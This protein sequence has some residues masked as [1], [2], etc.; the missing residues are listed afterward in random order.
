MTPIVRTF[1]W[2]AIVSIF[3]MNLFAQVSSAAE[4]IVDTPFRQE[5]RDPFVRVEPVVEKDEKGNPKTPPPPMEND[6][7]AVAA[8]KQ[9][10]VWAGTAAGVFDV[11]SGKFVNAPGE[12]INGPVY[13]FATAKD[14]VLWIGAWD[15][16]YKLIN[17][18]VE[19]EQGPPGPITAILAWDGKIVTAN[20]KG[21]DERVAGKWHHVSGPW[22]TTILDLAGVDSDLYVAA[23]NGLYRKSGEKVTYL[24]RPDEILSRNLS[25]LAVGP[26]GRLWIGSRG[27][28]DVYRGGKRERTIT[29]Q[30]GLPS[31]DV[32][33][34]RFDA[35]GTLWVG[36]ALGV[37]R[38]DGKGW[39]LRHSLRWV[40]NDEIRDVTFTDGGTAWIATKEGL[41]ILRRRNMTLAEKADGF[42]K[43]VRARHVRP[44]G[45]TESCVL[46]KPGNLSE[47]KPM[48]TDNDGLF[49]GLYL[50]AESYRYAATGAE[51]ARKNAAEAYAAM[52][53]LQTVTDTPGFVSRTVIPSDWSSM[54]DKNRTYTDQ[55]VADN[56]AREARWKKMEKRWR[57]SANG[58]W[59]WKGDTSSDEMSGHF[60][61]YGVYFDLAADE[62]EKKRVAK[63]VGRVMDY[64]IDGGFVLRD[65]DGKATRWGVWSPEKLN[66]DPNWWL[67]RGGNSVEILSY[68]TVAKHVTGDAKYD[69]EI[70][71][72]LTKHGYAKN[73]MTPMQP[74]RDYFTY[75]GHQLL[76]I[77]YPALLKYEND[78]ARRKLY[79]QSLNNWF[80]QIRHDGSPLY[81]FVYAS[82]GGGGEYLP[83]AC[84]ALLRDVP[85]D[86]IEWTVSNQNREDLK[87]VEK[88][89][90]GRVQTDRLL[91]PSER[92]IFRWDRNVYDVQRGDGG[93]TES[94]SVFWLLPYWMGRYH[95]LISAP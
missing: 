85:L 67:E 83:D 18:R 27:G 54:A 79:L 41:S 34:L 89:V 23:W 61:A 68:L 63:H 49:T 46:P 20:D 5:Y 22:A 30:E 77:S 40:P 25:A 2:F 82:L 28:I 33:S 74:G 16:V 26:D 92:G 66:D 19:R 53:Y 95:K 4:P 48:D 39:S 17:G 38:Y 13:D 86:M 75:I 8:D 35:E 90:E 29:G 73:I 43:Q 59:L 72:L 9:G 91:P 71:K 11:A 94:T 76:A 47:F 42:V 14:G 88:P 70:E 69:R 60:F 36:T 6:V 45:L 65:I 44:P 10:H 58:K 31:T 15:G 12:K 57:M 81:A 64:I 56:L 80:D 52:E 32:R 7:R 87:L 24:A 93:N 1:H 62:K 55:E 3:A 78:P 21:V 51:D 84:A 37:A 50:A